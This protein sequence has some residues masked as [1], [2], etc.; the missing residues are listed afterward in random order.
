V[1][2]SIIRAFA[3]D[4]SALSVLASMQTMLI[5]ADV[6]TSKSA[7]KSES[8]LSHLK[9]TEATAERKAEWLVEWREIVQKGFDELPTVFAASSA[10]LSPNKKPTIWADGAELAA[11]VEALRAAECRWQAG[12][13]LLELSTFDAYWPL[14]ERGT[15]SG[16]AL[17]EKIWDEQLTIASVRLGF[18]PGKARQIRH[19]VAAAHRTLSGHWR[20]IAIRTIVGIAGVGIGALTAGLAA[21]FIGGL[22][23]SSM[24][25]SGAVSVNAGLAAIGGALTAG[26]FGMAGG[27]A[28]I[29]GGGAILGFGAAG[30]GGY[31]IATMSPEQALLA[32]AKLEAMF[33][34]FILKD[35]RDDA[36]IRQILSAQSQAIQGVE[37]ELVSLIN[38]AEDNVKRLAPLKRRMEVLRHAFDRN[39][40]AAVG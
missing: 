14:E 29:V 13:V 35:P 6:K 28:V 15:Q 7:A 27:T 1:E 32:A 26:G 9:K 22:V 16:L 24:G 10:G 33:K 12:L 3:L 38:S 18:A 21:P 37:Q 4:A 5:D 34:E 36:F 31:T 39:Y 17:D 30:I 40:D 25:F 19:T 2:E 11:A 23:G 8:P 20:K